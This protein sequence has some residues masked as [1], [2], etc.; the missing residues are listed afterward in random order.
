[1]YCWAPVAI[2]AGS[3]ED[4]EEEEAEEAEEEALEVS[5]DALE[6]EFPPPLVGEQAAKASTK[7][8]RAT[9]GATNFFFITISPFE[10]G[11]VKSPEEKLQQVFFKI[12]SRFNRVFA[13]I[14]VN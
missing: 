14:Y 10:M 12:F 7:A 4:E 9:A 8:L 1:M 2:F 13:L 3:C 6:P 5:D 11:K